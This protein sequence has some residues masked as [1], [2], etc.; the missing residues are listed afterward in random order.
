MSTQKTQPGTARLLVVQ[1]D[2][3]GAI[4]QFG[5]WLEEAGIA[6][7][8]VRM[9]D[10][11]PVPLSIDAHGLLVLGG[12]MSSLDDDR[13]PWL[14]DVRRLLRRTVGEG[15]P[16]LGV[17]LGGQLMAQAIG[18]ATAKGDRGIETGVARVSWRPEA[19][20]DRLFGGLP[21]PFP[22][23]T[24]HSD[25]ISVLPEGAVW[26]GEGD[27]YPHQ[28][29]RV[30]DAAWGIQF[31][32]EIAYRHYQDWADSITASEDDMRAVQ[33]GGREFARSEAEV[34]RGTHG[35]ARRFAALLHERARRA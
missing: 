17:C 4:N 14:E 28:A 9:F 1:P 19:E 13:H 20:G 21:Q 29:Y 23:G 32:P 27:A 16:T 2:P 25:A 3:L 34:L 10:G 11:E 31:H 22:V 33:E 30:G 12:E 26:L 7:E 35:L 15:V 6:L 5:T 8:T 18:G 24:M